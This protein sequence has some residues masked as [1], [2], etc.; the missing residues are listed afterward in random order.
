[1]NHHDSE[2]ARWIEILARVGFVAKGLLYAVIGI[3][4][5]AA[6]LGRGGGTTDTRGAMAWLL[7]LPFGRALLIG[8]AVG[9]VGY[10][11]W[12]FVEGISDPDHRG[13]DAKGIALRTSFVARGAL[14]LWLAVS[15]VQ[16]AM[17]R[18]SS[19]SSEGSE[20]ATATAFLLPKGEWVV[21]AVAIGIAGFGAYQVYRALTAK[22]NRDVDTGEVQ[23]E[24]GGWLIVVSRI[25]IAARGLVFMAIGWLLF[26]AA[27]DHDPSE[28][29]GIGDAL[30]ALARLG[31]W[32][33]LAIAAGLIAYGV[34]QLINSRYRHIRAGDK[35]PHGG[36]GARSN[37][38]T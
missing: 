22:L 38:L 7:E 15:A 34:Y 10:A 14:H 19:S 20:R 31:R 23:Q 6:G 8:I 11:L 26:H 17:G 18:S 1:V 4:A 28:A 37:A 3:L 21:W 24:A 29:G 32:P 2:P 5:A 36:V 27:R 33:F 9:L 16:A 12:R 35:P 13:S 30:N 25:G